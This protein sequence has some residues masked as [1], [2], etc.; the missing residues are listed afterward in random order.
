MTKN[1]QRKHY[2]T[3]FK[4]ETLKLLDK[5]GVIQISIKLGIYSPQLYYWQSPEKDEELSVA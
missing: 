2:P 4:E 3:E 1:K 5:V